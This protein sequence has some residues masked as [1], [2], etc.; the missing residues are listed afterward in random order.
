LTEHTSASI[1]DFSS[2][3]KCKHL[4]YYEKFNDIGLA[5]SREKEMKKWGKRKKVALISKS[6]PHWE[7]LNERIYRTDDEYL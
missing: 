7:F 3:Y 5:I 6:N 4:V 1:P 2:R